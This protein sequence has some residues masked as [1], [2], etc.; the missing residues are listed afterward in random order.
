[1]KAGLPQLWSLTGRIRGVV[2]TGR[3]WPAVRM[4]ARLWYVHVGDRSVTAQAFGPKLLRGRG[5]YVN[6]CHVL[7]TLRLRTILVIVRGPFPA[8]VPFILAATESLLWV[9]PLLRERWPRGRPG[10]RP[11]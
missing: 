9:A 4:A 5:A 11:A 3:Q 10:P 2:I 7:P 6:L 8:I 1:M